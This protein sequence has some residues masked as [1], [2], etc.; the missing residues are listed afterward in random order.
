MKFIVF[1]IGRYT[2]WFSDLNFIVTRFILECNSISYVI[3]VRSNRYDSLLTYD[4]NEC[5]QTSSLCYREN[6]LTSTEKK[7]FSHP[8]QIRTIAILFI[9]ELVEDAK[10]LNMISSNLCYALHTLYILFINWL[11]IWNCHIFRDAFSKCNDQIDN[12]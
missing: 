3:F 11:K 2:F 7:N 10:C 5:C 6:Q 12:V 8:R 9:I 4:Q 1:N